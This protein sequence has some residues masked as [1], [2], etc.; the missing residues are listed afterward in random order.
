MR[1]VTMGAEQVLLITVPI[2][3]TLAVD[4]RP[5]VAELGAVALSA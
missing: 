5:P 4:P 1:A 2:A 3:R